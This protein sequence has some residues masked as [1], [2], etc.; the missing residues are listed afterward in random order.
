VAREFSKDSICDGEC[1]CLVISITPTHRGLLF[2]RHNLLAKI[3][4]D[5]S[6]FPLWKWLGKEHWI[7][8]VELQ[9][10]PGKRFSATVRLNNRTSIFVGLSVAY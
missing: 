1:K 9:V 10:K 2:P 6:A 8:L 4:K 7:G 5:S 3:S